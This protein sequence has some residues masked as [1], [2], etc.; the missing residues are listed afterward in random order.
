MTTITL[1]N[2]PDDIYHSLKSAA[3]THRRSLNSE[4]LACLEKML[5]PTRVASD[6]RLVRA[7][8]L[9]LSLAN[10]QFAAADIDAAIEQGRP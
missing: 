9:R 8:R 4:I 10:A 7:R 3:E 2:I 6:E 5:L 1:K